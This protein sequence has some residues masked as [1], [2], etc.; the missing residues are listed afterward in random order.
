MSDALLTDSTE[1]RRHLLVRSSTAVRVV[2]A[3]VHQLRDESAHQRQQIARRINLGNITSGALQL[4]SQALVHG[5]KA[6]AALDGSGNDASDESLA[7]LV[8]GCDL[9][10]GSESAWCVKYSAELC[11]SS[12]ARAVAPADCTYVPHSCRRPSQRSSLL[13]AYL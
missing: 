11:T 13:I 2:V 10:C 12:M 4:L 7:L 6:A 1:L 3:L 8:L 9:M 5:V